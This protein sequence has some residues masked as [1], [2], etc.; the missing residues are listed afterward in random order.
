MATVNSEYGSPVHM[1]PKQ[2]AAFKAL[3][4]GIAETLIPLAAA[5]ATETTALQIASL[6]QHLATL[7]GE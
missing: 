2:W 5:N 6:R 4:I 3:V 1:D 7:K